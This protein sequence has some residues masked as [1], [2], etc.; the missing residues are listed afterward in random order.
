MVSEPLVPI[1]APTK[2][3]KGTPH[4]P[5]M[6][7]VAVKAQM[8]RHVEW[9]RASDDGV[10]RGSGL[11]PFEVDVEGVQGLERF[12]SETV[13]MQQARDGER[14]EKEAGTRVEIHESAAPH[15][16]LDEPWIRP[17]LLWPPN[18]AVREPAEASSVFRRYEES[19]SRTLGGSSK[20]GRAGPR[21]IDAPSSTGPSSL[22]FC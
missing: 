17:E 9:V 1:Y 7:S 15:E 18:A 22:R 8:A 14:V 12:R 13:R 5:I 4:L 10:V 19:N 21:V 11:R 16:H 3:P 20:P 2:P 6:M